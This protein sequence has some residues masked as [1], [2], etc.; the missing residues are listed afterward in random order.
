MHDLSEYRVGYRIQSTARAVRRL[1]GAKQRP[2]LPRGKIRAERHRHVGQIGQLRLELPP[3][4]GCQYLDPFRST[5]E[6]TLHQPRADT[7]RHE[8]HIRQRDALAR[9]E[10]LIMPHL[11]DGDV[12]VTQDKRLAAHP[13]DDPARSMPKRM[14]ADRLQCLTT[15]SQ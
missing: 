2:D 14:G 1:P 9:I 13:R 10:K 11:Q 5:L 15:Y 3:K 12:G 8:R 7:Q 4:A 6:E